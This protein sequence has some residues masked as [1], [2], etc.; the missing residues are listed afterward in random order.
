MYRSVMGDAFDR[1]AT[2]IQQFHSIAGF[3]EF[4]GE[5]KVAE[6][7]SILAKLLA[8]FLGTPLNA[9][10]GPIRFEL[11][12]G[13]ATESW[14]RFFPGKTMHSSLTKSGH[15]VVERL[16]A[17]RL[18]FELVEVDKALEMRLEKFHFLGIS[19]P[20]WLSPKVMARESG[21]VNTLNFHI[22]ASVPFIGIVASYTGHLNIP[23]EA[24]E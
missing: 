7:A 8:I 24:C 15:R 6:P 10:Q 21:G 3:H 20:T 4:H 19:C 18:T 1:L 22:Q 13:P 16:G 12:A 14:T 17:S 9:S 23:S 2:P 5:V 11:A